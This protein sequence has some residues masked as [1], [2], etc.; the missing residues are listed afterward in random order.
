MVEKGGKVTRY[1]TKRM[2]QLEKPRIATA[3]EVLKKFTQ[4]LRQEAQEE[5]V[6][7]NQATGEFVTNYK[8][9]SISEVIKAGS[10]IMKRYPTGFEIEKVKLE[11]EKLKQD[12]L[13]NE[14]QDDK[15]T[16]IITTLKQ[17]VQ[18]EAS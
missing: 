9:P 3:D 15:L 2:K 8:T 10:E 13:G 6:E 4:I 5:I 11:I 18:N 1:I 17:A 14:E 16:T 7:L 12:L